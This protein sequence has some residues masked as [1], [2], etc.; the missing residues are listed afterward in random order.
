MND[1]G[2][3]LLAGGEGKRMGGRNKLNIP[4]K[5]STFGEIIKSELKEIGGKCF[6]SIAN[7]NCDSFDDFQIVYDKVRDTNGG[8]IGPLGGIYSTLEEAA[9]T[10][11]KGIYTVSCDMPFFNK[12]IFEAIDSYIDKYDI[13][14]IRTKDGH[15][16]H[17]CGYYSVSTIPVL[18]DM[19]GDRNYRI[20]DAYSKCNT[21]ILESDS[22]NLKEEWFRNINS[23]EE[24]KII[25]E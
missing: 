24:Y 4:Y 22:L 18:W 19:I 12:K 13:I 6:I 15:I 9:N 5:D 3:V 8:Y 2:Y 7:Y 23:T 21:F 25:T 14:L 16:H 10:G 11:L 20:R 17:T 1:V